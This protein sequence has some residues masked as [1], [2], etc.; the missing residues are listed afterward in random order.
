ML[1]CQKN[2][3]LIMMMLLEFVL[4]RWT[5]GKCISWD[6]PATGTESSRN[7]YWPR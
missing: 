6:K 7:S 5:S 2:S 1:S 4:G 3:D